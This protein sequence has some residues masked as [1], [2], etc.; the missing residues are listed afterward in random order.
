MDKSVKFFGSTTVGPKGQIVIPSK[1][2][3]EL[4]ISTGDQFLV[5]KNE[6]MDCVVLIKAKNIANMLND[7]TTEISKIK[8]TL[9]K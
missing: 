2:R 1:L 3:K 5:L 4:K 9:S 7:I 6:H 8:K